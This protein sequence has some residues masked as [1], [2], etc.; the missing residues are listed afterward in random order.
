[1][2]VSVAD[3]PRRFAVRS[4]LSPGTWFTS[5]FQRGMLS[6]ALDGIDV[7]HVL[8]LTTNELVLKVEPWSNLACGVFAA[9]GKFTI[10]AGDKRRPPPLQF[11]THVSFLEIGSIVF[12]ESGAPALGVDRADGYQFVDLDKFATLP[13]RDFS[14]PIINEWTLWREWKEEEVAL[15]CRRNQPN[16]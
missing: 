1:M 12:L 13:A 7:L 9:S 6:L 5:N 3:I 2:P 8:N 10:R 15:A 4:D 11:L 14:G 16:N